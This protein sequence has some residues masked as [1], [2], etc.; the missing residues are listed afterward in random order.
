MKPFNPKQI[1]V[2]EEERAVCPS[3][4]ERRGAYHFL[5]T[6]CATPTDR[7]KRNVREQ[8]AGRRALYG[9]RLLNGYS[10]NS[11]TCNQP[12]RSC[13]PFLWTSHPTDH[14][15]RMLL[16]WHSIRQRL[17]GVYPYKPPRRDFLSY[18]LS[19]LFGSIGRE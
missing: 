6:I 3:K 13:R 2:K 19:R 16:M 15:P 1:T 11:F 9:G 17:V 14:V 10:I 7:R 4:R 18:G 12:S 5:Q 8:M